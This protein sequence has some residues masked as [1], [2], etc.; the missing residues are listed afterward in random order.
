MTARHVLAT[1]AV[2]AALLPA[3]C[4]RTSGTA[5]TAPP[6]PA[7]AAAAATDYRTL[8]PAELETLIRSQTGAEAV[9][10]TPDGPNRYKG[11]ITAPG[12]T[13]VPATVTVEAGRVVCESKAGNLVS[14]QIITPNAPVK[15]ELIE[16]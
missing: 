13:P 11:Q 15:S 5:T 14:R 9:A 16:R 12:G 10:L 2:L 7:P 6:A 4:R 1:L 8:T 3:G